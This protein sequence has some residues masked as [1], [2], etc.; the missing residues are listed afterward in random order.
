M[1]LT[2]P[3]KKG[4]CIPIFKND[5]QKEMIGTAKLIQFVRDGRSFILEDAP[6]ERS[7]IVYNYQ[8]WEI[9]W[10]HN[11]HKRAT[12][13]QKIYFIDS[14]G[15]SNSADEDDYEYERVKLDEDNF[16]TEVYALV[17]GERVLQTIQL[18]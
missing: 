12:R 16:S 3:Y 7:Q 15:L 2:F 8:V 18:Y 9:E 13:P 14:I 17:D 6:T 1:K 5:Q 11:P 4:D 10:L